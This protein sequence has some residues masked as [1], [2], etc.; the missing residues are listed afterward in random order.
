MKK[1]VGL[2]RK[3]LYVVPNRCLEQFGREFVQWCTDVKLWI[4]SEADF[5]E[6]RRKALTAKITTSD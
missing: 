1:Q 6:E 5:I 3:P 2:I 4:A